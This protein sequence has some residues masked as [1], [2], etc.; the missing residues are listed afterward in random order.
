MAKVTLAIS[1]DLDDLELLSEIKS[2]YHVKN[3]SQ[4]LNLIIRQWQSFMEDRAKQQESI[5][6]NKKIPTLADKYK[7]KQMNPMVM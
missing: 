3:H 4:A 6:E 7:L 1:I 2:K 5:R